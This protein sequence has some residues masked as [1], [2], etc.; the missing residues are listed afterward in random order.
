[1]RCRRDGREIAPRARLTAG[2]M[3]LQYAER[4]GL[5]KYACPSLRV[6]LVGSRIERQR[7][8][9]VRTAQRTAVRQLGQ[10]AERA[11]QSGTVSCHVEDS[12]VMGGFIPAI[13]VFLLSEL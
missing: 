8:G 11:V 9:A 5:C 3:H 10:K 13:Y 4:G 7:I 12:S 6:E 1:M 2:Q